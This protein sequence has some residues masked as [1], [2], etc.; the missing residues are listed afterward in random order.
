M[1][2]LKIA[3]FGTSYFSA[4]FLEKLMLDT[5]INRLI[6]L[7]LVV[8]QPD[9]PVGRKNIL[10]PSS[11]KEVAKK[12]GVKIQATGVPSQGSHQ[13]AEFFQPVAGSS[14]GGKDEGQDP[15]QNIDLA[16]LFAYGEIIPKEILKLPKL[17]FWNVHPS[18]LPKYRG[19]SPI[20]SPLI[21]GDK[22]TGVTLIQLDDKVDH[23]PIIAQEE[24][25][26]NPKD[27]RPDL[28]IKLTNLAY[29]M[30]KELVTGVEKKGPP[31]RAARHFDWSSEHWGEM[32]SRQAPSNF[33]EQDHTQ[34]TYTRLLK[35]EDG[36][37]LLSDLKR[38]REENGTMIYNRFR[39]LYPWPGIWTK[40]RIKE[41]DLRLK[42]I[43]LDLVENGRDR[44]L[45]IKTVQLEGKKE[46][47]FGTFNH[48]YKVF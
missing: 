38:A 36:F 26:I 33:K 40:V 19:P 23:G 37:V 10:S 4:I 2:K 7:K 5:S 9:K 21:V 12:F 39:G 11:V 42:I 34:A 35:K 48:A 17:G 22:K 20:A 45:Q 15:L 24:L 46:V 47:C 3:Y 27:R 1:K 6:E 30:F 41:K 14:T 32:N 25:F 13:R 16:I 43:D 8:T 31:Q 29:E 18:L 28:E 44:S